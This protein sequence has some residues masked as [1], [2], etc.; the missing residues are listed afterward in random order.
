[1]FAAID[2]FLEPE[3]ETADDVFSLAAA[4]R[5][6][7]GG[8]EAVKRMVPVLESEC[9]KRLEEIRAGLAERDAKKVQRGAHTIKGSAQVFAAKRVATA[10]R[11]VEDMARNGDVAGAEASLPALNDEVMRLGQALSSALGAK[12]DEGAEL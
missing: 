12:G 10:A 7:P 5:R 4:L 8:I 1:M 2:G 6:I 9:S 3:L 11:R